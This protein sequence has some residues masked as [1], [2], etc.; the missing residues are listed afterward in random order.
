MHIKLYFPS[1]QLL[2]VTLLLS[3]FHVS[4]VTHFALF[5][6]A[7]APK[8]FIPVCSHI[9]VFHALSKDYKREALL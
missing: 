4:P 6:I 2:A 5:Y 7:K 1:Y 9:Y 3:T 8:V